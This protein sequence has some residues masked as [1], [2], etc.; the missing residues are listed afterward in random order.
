MQTSTAEEAVR[1]AGPDAVPLRPA[2]AA[3]RAVAA[4][5]AVVEGEAAAAVDVADVAVD[6]VADIF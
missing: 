3:V 4:A 2:V 1:V 5:A 6:M